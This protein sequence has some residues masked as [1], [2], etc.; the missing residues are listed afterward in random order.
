MVCAVHRGSESRVFVTIDKMTLITKCM[1]G[2]NGTAT[3][4]H[5]MFIAMNKVCPTGEL[6]KLVVDKAHATGVIESSACS[7]IT[8]P[9]R[10][11]ISQL[12]HT[13]KGRIMG[14]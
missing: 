14:R 7:I 13:V 3:V 11:L 4:L 2:R 6:F 5:A 8:P 1:Y 12:N 9:L 10:P